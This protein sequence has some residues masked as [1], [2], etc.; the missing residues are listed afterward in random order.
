[1]IEKYSPAFFPT[2]RDR[3]GEIAKVELRHLPA[4]K[5][6]ASICAI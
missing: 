4:F 2:G 3:P 5:A 6:D 1:M